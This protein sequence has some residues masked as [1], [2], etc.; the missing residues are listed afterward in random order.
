MLGA[1]YNSYHQIV[2]SADTVA[3]NMEMMHDARIVPLDGRAALPETIQQRLGSSRGRWEGDTLV[4]ETTNFRA[5]GQ[6]EMARPFGG[7][8]ST[9]TAHL[10]ERFTRVGPTTLKYEVTVNDPGTYTKPWT[11]V[12]YWKAEPKDQMLRVRLPRG[13]RGHG[14][15]AQWLSRPGEGRRR[16]G[17]EGLPVSTAGRRVLKADLGQTGSAPIPRCP[18]IRSKAA[19]EQ[20]RIATR[21][22]RHFHRYIR[23]GTSPTRRSPRAAD[24]WGSAR[25]SRWAA[26]AHIETRRPGRG[27]P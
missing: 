1:G 2:Q 21:P 14:G 18:E 16:S 17:E 10:T 13:K 15:H 22:R 19:G 5:R 26:R 7:R 4:V 25:R 24:R 27:R 6:V 12:S 11:A 8:M 23:S 3:I 9:S 20:A